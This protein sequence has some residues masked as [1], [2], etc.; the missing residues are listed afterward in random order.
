MDETSLFRVVGW[1]PFPLPGERRRRRQALR[2]AEELVAL[3]EEATVRQSSPTSGERPAAVERREPS[4]LPTDRYE[5]KIPRSGAEACVIGIIP[6]DILDVRGVAIWV[7]GENTDMDMARETENSIS[8]IIRY[9]GGRP[10][11]APNNRLDK[12]DPNSDVIAHLLAA[13][14]G[15]AT[16]VAPGSA[17]QTDSGRL[18]QS[19]GVRK[20]IHVAAVHGEPGAGY[21]RVPNIGRCVSNAL[22]IANDIAT[23]DPEASSILFPLLGTGMGGAKLEPT[24][25]TLVEAARRY[26][27]DGAVPK[28]RRIYFLAYTD[29]EQEVLLEVLR[30]ELGLE[31]VAG[32]ASE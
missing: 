23:D 14:V 19:N 27:E 31:L 32:A 30:N 21:Q 3:A 15:D 22:N 10:R 20:I 6:G 26:V 16:P 25:R 24:V 17:F 11:P 8:A 9:W 13:A 1:G 5:F 7:N 29:A 12:K 28:V 18:R 4:S 2:A